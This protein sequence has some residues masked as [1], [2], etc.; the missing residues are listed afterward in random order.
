MDKCLY[1]ISHQG[2]RASLGIR[3]FN[4]FESDRTFKVANEIYT[5]QK[6]A[7]LKSP[8][9][10]G[11]THSFAIEPTNELISHYSQLI[12][13]EPVDTSLSAMIEDRRC[14]G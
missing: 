2:K 12:F 8:Y 1:L 11:I 9:L 4:S 3:K 7:L 5:A 6:V 13:M 14:R 10:H